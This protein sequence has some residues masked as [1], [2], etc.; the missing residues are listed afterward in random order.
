MTAAGAA[1]VVNVTDAAE[2]VDVA[3]A[4]KEADVVDT[5]KAADTT[6]ASDTVDVT[7]LSG[8]KVL[9]I[10]A[11]VAVLLTVGVFV[12]ALFLGVPSVD[13]YI[14]QGTAA[15]AQGDYKSAIGHFEKAD[16]AG[17]SKNTGVM[18]LLGQAYFNDAQYQKA[19]DTMIKLTT[20]LSAGGGS[21]ERGESAEAY[22]ILAEARAYLHDA[23]GT[24]AAIDEGLL[25]TG[26]V[27]F[28]QLS[29]TLMIADPESVC[30][31]GHYNGR[32]LFRF[33]KVPMDTET[34]YTFGDAAQLTDLLTGNLRQDQLNGGTAVGV[35]RLATEHDGVMPFELE[36][37]KHV[38]TAVNTNKY[39]MSS[40]MRTFEV[41]VTEQPANTNANLQ[42]GGY[43]TVQGD[44]LYYYTGEG[45][46]REKTD[47]SRREKIVEGIQIQHLNAQGEWLYFSKTGIG[48]QQ[49]LYRV[50]LD[51]SRLSR[52]TQD[53]VQ[54]IQIVPGLVGIAD[55]PGGMGLA[56]GVDTHGKIFYIGGD[57]D[58][59]EYGL[60]VA[61]LNGENRR[62]LCAGDLSCLNYA[63][64]Y[65][66]FIDSGFTGQSGSEGLSKSDKYLADV[67]GPVCR[68]SLSD[69]AMQRIINKPVTFLIHENGRLYYRTVENQGG[70]IQSATV[71]GDAWASTQTD[72]SDNAFWVSD[73]RFLFYSKSANRIYAMNSNDLS[74]ERA[75]EAGVLGLDGMNF[76]GNTLYGFYESSVKKEFGRTDLAQVS[77]DVVTDGTGILNEEGMQNLSAEGSSAADAVGTT[78]PDGNRGFEFQNLNDTR[79]CAIYTGE[80]L[81][82]TTADDSKAERLYV[83]DSQMG[84]SQAGDSHQS[85]WEYQ[86]EGGTDAR[87]PFTAQK[88][89]GLAIQNDERLIYSD[90]I[91]LLTSDNRNVYRYPMERDATETLSTASVIREIERDVDLSATSASGGFEAGSSQ[92]GTEDPSGSELESELESGLESEL[93]GGLES[94][95]ESEFGSGAESLASGESE[96]TGNQAAGMIQKT[97]ISDNGLHIFMGVS[98]MVPYNGAVYFSSQAG[99]FKA[100]AGFTS[101]TFL[102]DDGPQS[103]SKYLIRNGTVFYSVN[104]GS[105]NGGIY[106]VELDGSGKR[107]VVPGAVMDFDVSGSGEYLY[108]SGAQDLIVCRV[109]LGNGEVMRMND[110]KADRLIVAGERLVYRSTGER[111]GL[112]VLEAGER[113]RP[114]KLTEGGADNLTV[115]GDDIFYCDW[116]DGGNLCA[117]NVSTGTIKQIWE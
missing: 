63:D 94:D 52:L 113:S 44:W 115:F 117:V 2:V 78:S 43:V 58:G 109:T 22:Y 90:G 105:E 81:L 93:E 108:F 1:E 85:V 96:H 19:A 95:L 25:Q 56:A 80:T 9:L 71:A 47:G 100:N 24:Q 46:T 27:R 40:E 103:D 48:S 11:A 59:G 54:G 6:K 83:D 45:I 36:P 66:Y 51:G 35:Y 110:V 16:R 37:G 31:S 64:G 106:A 32:F 82:F 77:W 62:L 57:Y 69:G 98:G 55:M 53:W 8:M 114:R 116:Q 15:L 10:A 3:D 73:D 102:F 74:V 39:G 28:E 92:A 87:V 38:I 49:G 104:G 21:A 30:E 17:K 84:D 70:N 4:T 20:N 107:C 41:T 68:Y 101:V 33:S 89:T 91:H 42:N 72:I 34:L 61:D 88:L 86:T 7:K 97:K 14:E 65:L 79:V 112:F 18:L 23:V 76:V 111:L 26:D 12:Y 13:W 75:V 60:F 67:A 99:F 29:E 50:R 5:T